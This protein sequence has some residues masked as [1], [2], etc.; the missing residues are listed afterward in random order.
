[1]VFP[2]FHNKDRSSNRW[3]RHFSTKSVFEI[4]LT[5]IFTQTIYEQFRL[6]FRFFSLYDV[7]HVFL[8]FIKMTKLQTLFFSLSFDS[9]TEF[10]SKKF[11]PKN[12]TISTTAAIVAIVMAMCQT[13]VF[14][15][16][17]VNFPLK[18]P[19]EHWMKRRRYRT[20]RKCLWSTIYQT[21][22][23]FDYIQLHLIFGK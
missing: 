7:H 4:S 3:N 9:K 5:D 13:N 11:L 18:C 23:I 15:F 6:N 8:R 22:K 20:G 21:P 16:Y 10:Y 14:P 19:L 17:L 1:M 12:I 2:H